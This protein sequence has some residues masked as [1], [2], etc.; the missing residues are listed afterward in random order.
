MTSAVIHTCGFSLRTATRIAEPKSANISPQA[1]RT[2]DFLVPYLYLGVLV[3]LLVS[4][5]IDAGFTDLDMVTSSAAL[6]Q[7]VI[8]VQSRL[9]VHSPKFPGHWVAYAHALFLYSKPIL[10]QF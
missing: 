10:P 7:P 9:F 3:L 5:N 8:S 6:G 2:L 4:N 1:P